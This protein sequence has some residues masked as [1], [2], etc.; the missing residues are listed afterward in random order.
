[1]PAEE[2]FISYQWDIQ[3]WVKELKNKL[4]QNGISCWMDI[5]QMGGGDAMFAEIDAGMRAAKVGCM[6]QRRLDHGSESFI[7]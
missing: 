4:E 3:G 2:V 7:L 5:G 1:M 6:I